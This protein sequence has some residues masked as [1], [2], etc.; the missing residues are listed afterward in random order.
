MLCVWWNFEGVVHFEL[1]QN[2]QAINAELYCQQLDRVY[3]K[4]K[5]KYP[6]L[7]NRKRALLQQDNAK[8][9][10]A[11]KTTGRFQELDGVEILPHPAY[12]PDWLNPTMTSSDPCNTS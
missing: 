10:T 6:A 11:K 2:G 12:S 1:V 7:I 8:P 5:E 3:E 4:L 9:H